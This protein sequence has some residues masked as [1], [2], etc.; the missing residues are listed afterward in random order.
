MYATFKRQ[1]AEVAKI[2]A[3]NKKLSETKATLE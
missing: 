2:E 3:E 1:Q